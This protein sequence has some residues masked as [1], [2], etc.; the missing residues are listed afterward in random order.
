MKV[1]QIVKMKIFKDTFRGMK[2]QAIDLET[3]FED[4]ISGK[5]FIFKYIKSSHNSIIRKK[6]SNKRNKR[7]KQILHQ[8]VYTDGQ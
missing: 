2:K 7:Y 1:L 4:H 5:G 8:R 6:Q 3:L